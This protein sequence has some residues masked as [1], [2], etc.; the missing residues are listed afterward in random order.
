MLTCGLG[1]PGA[2]ETEEE[3]AV[4]HASWWGAGGK[5]RPLPT[6]PMVWWRGRPGSCRGCWCPLST[7][8]WE[9]CPGGRLAGGEEWGD[10]ERRAGWE[11]WWG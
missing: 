1:L 4:P 10:W 3:P 9:K 2:V 8:A 5:M 11:W 7:A 6:P